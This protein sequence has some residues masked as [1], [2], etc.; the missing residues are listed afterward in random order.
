MSENIIT[1][2]L[3]CLIEDEKEVPSY[4]ENTYFQ[5][6]KDTPFITEYKWEGKVDRI[7]NETVYATMYSVEDQEWDEFV[8][9]LNEIDEDDR[10]LVNEGALFNF[11]NAALIDFPSSASTIL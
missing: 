8:F 4:K 10:K 9:S 6:S 1:S 2:E 3:I 7:E 11:Y 5:D